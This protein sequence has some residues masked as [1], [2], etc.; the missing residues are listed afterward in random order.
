MTPRGASTRTSTKS[1]RRSRG[2]DDP[3][4][5]R[6]TDQRR[7][8]SPPLIPGLPLGIGA[9]DDGRGADGAEMRGDWLG[10]DARGAG[11]DTRGAPLGAELRCGEE[12]VGE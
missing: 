1:P 8:P 10:A 9:E 12:T 6:A 2:Q 11:A 7:L 3:S 5:E 4:F